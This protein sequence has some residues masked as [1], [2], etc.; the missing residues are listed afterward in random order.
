M[1]PIVRG[2]IFMA[3][4]AGLQAIIG[5]AILPWLLHSSGGGVTTLALIGTIGAGVFGFVTGIV[6]I[7]ALR[8]LSIFYFVIDTTW[9]A[10][11][12]ASG[13]F[14]MIYCAIVG[15]FETPT[16]L[17]QDWGTIRFSGAAL[18]NA[19]GSTI[20]TVMGDNGTWLQHE[21][22]HLVQARIFG[23]FYWPTYL[24]SYVFNM[25]IRFLTI[26]F[27]APHDEAYRRTIMEDW[28]YHGVAGSEYRIGPWIGF[29]F[30][31]LLHALAVAV[32]IAPIPFVGA[33]PLAIGLSIVPWWIGLIVLVLYAAIRSYIGGSYAI[34]AASA[35]PPAPAGAGGPATDPWH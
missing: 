23:P 14:F 1:P 4:G 7:Y 18:P 21:T 26:R 32:M 11:N 5:F 25:L 2:L 24:L 6:G 13:L 27:S 12:T 34:P 22:I 10:L 9:S 33:I 31:G 30:L 16:E 35:S 17:T 20:G 19:D 8:P 29:F 3:I 28:A 15:K